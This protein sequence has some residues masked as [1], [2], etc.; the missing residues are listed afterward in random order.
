[1][2]WDSGIF[3]FKSNSFHASDYKQ[4]GNA[5]ND[6]ME[7][8]TYDNPSAL[9][10]GGLGYT[11]ALTSSLAGVTSIYAQKGSAYFTLL[12]KQNIY[13]GKDKV[14]SINVEYVHNKNSI[15]GTVGFSYSGVSVVVN[16]SGLKDSVA[17][18]ANFRY[19]L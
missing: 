16:L 11:V 18:A 1:M 5:Y 12:P 3:T 17:T 10:Q 7:W 8:L 4:F 19:K 9:N 14:S 6:W 13:Y 15:L 2:N